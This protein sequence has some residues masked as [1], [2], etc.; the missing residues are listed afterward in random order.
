MNRE[1]TKTL[2]LCILVMM[3]VVLVQQI[4]FSS[5]LHILQSQAT[6]L[7]KNQETIKEIRN[8]MVMPKRVVLSFGDNSYTMLSSYSDVSKVWN[9]GSNILNNYFH[10]DPEVTAVSMEVYEETKSR[11]A[12]ELEFA[13]GVPSTL[14]ATGFDTADNKIVRSVKEIYKILIPAQHINTIYIVGGEGVIFEV[15]LENKEPQENLTEFISDLESNKIDFITYAPIFDFLDN[16]TIIPISTSMSFT[17]NVPVHQFFVESQ[18]DINDEQEVVERAKSFFNENFDFVKTIRETSGSLVYMYGY[19]ERGVRIN[20]RGRLEYNEDI[21][22]ESSTNVNDAL[23]VAIDFIIDHGDFPE[24]VYL[25]EIRNITHNTNKGY[26]FGFGYRIAGFPVELSNSQMEDPIEIEVYGNKIKS[27]RTFTREK[28]KNTMSV[29]PQISTL[30]PVDIIEQ[31]ATDIKSQHP[32]DEITNEARQNEELTDAQW[33]AKDID[34]VTMVYFDALEKQTQQL[35]VPAWM[36][37][38]EENRY[39]FDA[40]TGEWINSSP[41][42]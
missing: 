36:I 25:N 41:Q 17:E 39:F 22:S 37:E 32:Y 21:G 42:N 26:Y 3:T 34:L 20:H 19:G 23:D 29:Q 35:L 5:P 7:R 2:I 24:G 13:K 12:I 14:V 6:N 38:I 40:Y 16:H 30:S 28:M 9:Q 8:I 15:K 33:I 27:Y 31:N 18:I 1:K 4:W 10:G 11:K